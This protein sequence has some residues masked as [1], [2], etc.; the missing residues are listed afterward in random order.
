M[1]E[2]PDLYRKCGDHRFYR[3]RSK[4]TVIGINELNRLYEEL[5]E[6]KWLFTRLREQF[7]GLWDGETEICGSDLTMELTYQIN[8]M[9][10]IK[11]IG[12]KTLQESILEEW[13]PVD[14]HSLRDPTE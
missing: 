14:P 6:F 8:E 9:D 3:P 10:R 11:L 7:P 5:K 12:H 1:N 4:R 2:L 13:A